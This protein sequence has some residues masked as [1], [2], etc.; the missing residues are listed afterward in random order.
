M[1]SYIV[2]TVPTNRDLNATFFPLS[3]TNLK[4]RIVFGFVRVYEIFWLFALFFC[5]CFCLEKSDGEKIQFSN[6]RVVFSLSIVIIYYP[7]S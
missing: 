7:L 6:L 2:E 4:R 1:E 5:C 3:N